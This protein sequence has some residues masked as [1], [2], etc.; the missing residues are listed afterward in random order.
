MTKEF[1]PPRSMADLDA[2]ISNKLE[3]ISFDKNNHWFS[4]TLSQIENIKGLFTLNFG[5]SFSE[6]N[7]K[8]SC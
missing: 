1:E 4:K 3:V 2:S 7:M 6:R 8:E 5:C